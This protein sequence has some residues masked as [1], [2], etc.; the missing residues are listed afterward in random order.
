MACAPNGKCMQ[1]Y[2][3]VQSHCYLFVFWML[4]PM[5][6]LNAWEMSVGI[7]TCDVI[8]WF[9]TVI[10]LF[11]RNQGRHF[12]LVVVIEPLLMLLLWIGFVL[13]CCQATHNSSCISLLTKRRRKWMVKRKSQ[14]L[15][16]RFWSDLRYLEQF[17]VDVVCRNQVHRHDRHVI[18]YF[19]VFSDADGVHLVNAKWKN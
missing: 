2:W 15:V 1:F 17:D 6:S 4:S 16:L 12:S 18:F 5:S 7:F 9:Q 8:W 3:I 11:F 13:K 19:R 10:F 14:A